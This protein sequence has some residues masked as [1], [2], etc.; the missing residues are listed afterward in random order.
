MRWNP[1][2]VQYARAHGHSPEEQ[3][4]ED[5][6]QYP[7]GTGAG[8]LCWMSRQ[9]AAFKTAHREAFIG[10]SIAERRVW[11]LWL[12]QAGASESD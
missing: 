6:S 10:D 7:G 5:R 8:F 11:E 3:L 9:R 12:K 4:I 1:Y 2:F